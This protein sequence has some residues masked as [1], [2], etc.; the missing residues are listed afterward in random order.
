MMSRRLVAAALA[1]FALGTGACDQAPTEPNR[2]SATDLFAAALRAQG[3]S[4]SVEGAVP[5]WT[6]PY[7]SPQATQLAAAI[8]EV[9]GPARI[10]VFEYKREADAAAE[11]ANVRSD[12][13]PSRTSLI[14]WVATPRFYRH[15]RLIALYVG[16][17]ARILGALQT[18]AGSPFVVG[19]TP[20][21]LSGL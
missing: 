17:D 4:V 19:S 5:T 1:V 15:G 8:S 20:C 11:A 18:V 13:Q 3:L 12:G 21:T 10:L 2:L 9:H 6:T 7:F 16:C 14:T